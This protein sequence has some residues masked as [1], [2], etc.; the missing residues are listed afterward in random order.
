ARLVEFADPTEI[1]TQRD[2][3][4]VVADPLPADHGHE[5]RAAGDLDQFTRGR[6]LDDD[7]VADGDLAGLEDL[8]VDPAVQVPARGVEHPRNVD[9]DCGGPGVDRRRRAPF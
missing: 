4:D 9:V 5:P 2:L 7:L 6:P 3:D 8:T 1:V